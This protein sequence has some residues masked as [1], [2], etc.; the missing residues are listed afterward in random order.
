MSFVST[1]QVE[2]CETPLTL[3]EREAY[4]NQQP[5]VVRQTANIIKAISALG[6]NGSYAQIS[7]K[8]FVLKTP[9]SIPRVRALVRRGLSTGVFRTTNNTT[10][11]INRAMVT[12]NVQ[13]MV[14]MRYTGA[15][16]FNAQYSGGYRTASFGPT[17]G[18]LTTTVSQVC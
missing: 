16:N 11:G 17:S 8:L 4:M 1:V 5:L 14:Y 10:F 12:S 18:S 7:Y 15:Q 13:N 9:L 6:K 3:A 2:T